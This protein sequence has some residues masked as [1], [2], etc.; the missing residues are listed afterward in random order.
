MKTESE[1]GIKGMSG[2]IK[3]WKEQGMSSLETAEEC[4][5]DNLILDL[6]SLEL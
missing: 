3:S 4:S 5:S 2:S 6:R 1:I